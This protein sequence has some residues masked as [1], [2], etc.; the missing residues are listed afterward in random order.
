MADKLP[1]ISMRMNPLKRKKKKATRRRKA[2]R[3]AKRKARKPA[4]RKTAARFKVQGITT[5][6]RKVFWLAPSGW[7]TASSAARKFDSMKTAEAAMR[8]A[9]RAQKRPKGLWLVQVVPA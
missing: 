3:P 9:A 2:A 1:I 8:A 7:G 5:P 4:R 6:A